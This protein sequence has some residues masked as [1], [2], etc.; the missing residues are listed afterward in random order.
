MASEDEGP[1]ES[2]IDNHRTSLLD[3]I[4]DNNRAVNK[5]SLLHRMVIISK[6][7]NPDVDRSLVGSQYEAMLKNLQNV[8]QSEVISGLMLIYMKHVVHVVESSID[9][10]LEIVKDLNQGEESDDSFISESKILV[11]SHNI[12]FYKNRY[13]VII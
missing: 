11:I 7:R 5:K 13:V 1:E 8:Y 4:E 9:M 10:L 12:S 6:L 3:I 2:L